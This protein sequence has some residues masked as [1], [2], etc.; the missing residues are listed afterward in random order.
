M[1][2]SNETCLAYGKLG[3]FQ[4]DCLT[5]KTSTPLYPSSNKSYNKPKFHTNS[6]PQQNQNV[7]NHQKD[8]KG[9][10]KGFKAEIAILTKKID[11]MSKGKSEKGLVAESFDW[12]EES[13]SSKDEGVTKV[14]VYMDIDENEPS[15][16]KG[17][18]RSDY[19]HVDIHYVEEQRKNLLIKF[20]SLNQELSS[21][22]GNIVHALGGRGKKKDTISSKEVLFFKEIESLSETIPK[23]TS[24]SEFECDN[25]EPLPPLPKLT[26]A[27]PIGTSADVLTL[28]Y[29]TQNPAV[30]EEI[31]KVLDKRS[32]IKALKKK[33]QTVSSSAL[34]PILVKKADSSTEQLLLTLMKEVKGL[35][36][37]IKIPSDTS[38]SVSQ[39][40]SSKSAKGKQNTWFGP[41][42]HHGF[43]NHF[44]ED[45]YMK[46]KCST[47]GST[48]HLTKEH[49]EQVVVRKTLAK[50]KAQSSQDSSSRKAPMIQNPFI[51]YKYCGFNDHHS[52][53]VRTTLDVTFAAYLKRFIRY[54]DS[55]YSRHMIGVKQYLHRYSNKLRSKVV[56]GDNSL[57]DIEGYGLVNC[58]GVT[59]TKVAYVNSLKHNLISISQLCDA[60]IKVLFIKTHG[61]IF[62]QNNKVVLIAPRRRDVYVFDM[63]SYNEESNACFFAKASNS[64]NWLWHKRL[65]HLSFKN[66]NK[67]ARQ[68]LVAGLPSLTFSKDKTYSACEKGKHHRASFKTKRLFSINKCLHLLHMNLFGPVKPQS[69]SHN[70]YTLVIVDEYSRYTWV[71]CL[72]KKSDAVDRIM[73]FIRKMENLNEVKAKELRSDNGTE[74]RNYK[75]K[76]FCD[77][78]GIS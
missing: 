72:K 22:S 27:E 66:I 57:G 8:Y 14:N 76:E 71:F 42:K 21:L 2:K 37:Q 75:L 12:D 35:K 77:E 20:N 43:R 3:H 50:L 69:I 54:I 9:K 38:P 31:K 7:D 64:V 78:K 63:S 34:D 25:L 33:A 59:F 70:K 60:N 65:S 44:L 19:T 24:N 4:K 15:V 39:S 74:F 68:N 48:D 49:P 26:K 10:Y 47:C 30:S 11:V 29:L 51:D 52:M 23:I 1:D 13:V 55:G 67:L 5:T 62:N 36:E 46:P 6:T 16:G 32:A 28:A 56:F 58:N 40:G 53:S 41:C 73:S 45:C 61:T 18:A 17:D